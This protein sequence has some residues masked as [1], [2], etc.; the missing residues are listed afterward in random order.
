MA[1]KDICIFANNAY[2]MWKSTELANLRAS[3]IAVIK[4]VPKDKYT[5]ENTQ[6]HSK[7]NQ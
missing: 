4:T 7:I 5:R 2:S 3:V 1:L 6:I